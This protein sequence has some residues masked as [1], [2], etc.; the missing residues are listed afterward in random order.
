MSEGWYVIGKNGREVGPASMARIQAA[1]D[2]GKI[3]PATLVRK[4]DAEP[5][6]ANQVQELRFEPPQQKVLPDEAAAKIGKGGRMVGS[7]TDVE[8]KLSRGAGRVVATTLG[9]PPGVIWRVAFLVAASLASFI[10]GV[11]VGDEMS[12]DARE[13]LKDKLALS[14][15]NIDL[16]HLTHTG[17]YRRGIFPYTEAAAIQQLRKEVANALI[18]FRAEM[19]MGAKKADALIG[20]LVELNPD[21]STSPTRDEWHFY[22]IPEGDLQYRILAALEQI[23]QLPDTQ[24]LRSRATDRLVELG[25]SDRL[26]NDDLSSNLLLQQDGDTPFRR[27]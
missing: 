20:A 23:A 4:V 16:Y 18:D 3:G 19:I 11:E 10:A 6:P 27:W 26:N 21:F 22:Y 25:Y 24:S 5:R 1:I 7:S 8:A 15:E 14:S 17:I 13:L 12:P 9:E 2:A